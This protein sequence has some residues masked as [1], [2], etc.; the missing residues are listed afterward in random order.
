MFIKQKFLPDG[1][2][3]TLKARLAADGSQQG[4][5]LYDFVSSA[6]VSLQVLYLLFN[7]ASYYK[8]MLQTVD[9]RG[10]FLN[11][12]FTSNDKPI[13]LR[14]N[15]DIVNKDTPRSLGSSLS[16]RTRTTYITARQVSLRVKAVT[17]KVPT[18]S[19]PHAR[20]RR[21]HA[22]HQWR[23]PI[24]QKQRIKVQLCVY[25]LGQLSSL[26]QLPNNG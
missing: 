24:L 19:L 5:H 7:I 22:I 18:P 9:I 14:I 21:V 6:T 8:C 26:R 12:Q 17:F 20:H 10:A 1:N 15:K 11:A 3:D 16:H 23:M 2:M 25:S 4:R 13:C